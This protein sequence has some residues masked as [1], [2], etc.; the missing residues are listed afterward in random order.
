M[1]LSFQHISSRSIP[2]YRAYVV[3]NSRTT[4]RAA[5][6]AVLLRARGGWVPLPQIMA[7]AAQYN[8]R[9]H[10]LRRLNFQIENRIET[11]NGVRRSAF[12][13]DL[14]PINTRGATHETAHGMAARC[15]AI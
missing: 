12:R 4:Q 1:L 9:V 6:L 11:V 7:C 3:T 8:A 14:A 2:T 13:L 15:S 5:I 10:E